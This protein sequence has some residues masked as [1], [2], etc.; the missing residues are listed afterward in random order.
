ML[1]DMVRYR[2]VRQTRFLTG[3]EMLWGQHD[4]AQRTVIRHVSVGSKNMNPI[5][6]CRSADELLQ[7]VSHAAPHLILV[8][9][10]LLSLLLFASKIGTG[11]EPETCG[12]LGFVAR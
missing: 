6:E 4:E 11:I 12:V 9:E 5:K 1:P 8:L 3:I 7:H 10:A 2:F